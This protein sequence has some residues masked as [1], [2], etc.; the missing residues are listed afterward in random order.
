M[1]LLLSCRLFGLEPVFDL[2]EDEI[3]DVNHETILWI[4]KEW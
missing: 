2:T 3:K 4:I 1:H